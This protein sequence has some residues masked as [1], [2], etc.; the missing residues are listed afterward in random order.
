MLAVNFTI[1]RSRFWYNFFFTI[2]AKIMKELNFFKWCESEVYNSDDP[3]RKCPESIVSL[4]INVKYC[5]IPKARNEDVNNP[6]SVY[7]RK[8]AKYRIAFRTNM[9]MIIVLARETKSIC[10]CMKPERSKT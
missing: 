7:Y 9:E 3:D 1:V 2:A 4:G 6:G 5:W 10:D 8:I